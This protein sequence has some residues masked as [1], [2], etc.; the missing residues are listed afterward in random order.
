MKI[1]IIYA[2]ESERGNITIPG[3]ELSFC[4]TGVGKVSAALKTYESCLIEKPD[5]VLG[6]GTAGTVRYDVGDI[7]LCSR[8]L[9]R[10]LFKIADLGVSFE[11][12]FEKELKR[13][14]LSSDS[15]GCVSSGDTFQTKVPASG[16]HSDVYDMEAYG[17]AQACKTLGIPFL[18]LKYVTDIIGRNSMK[19]WE[20]KLEDAKMGLEN[21]LKELIVAV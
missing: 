10:D 7:V 20:E 9:D 1:L 5:L 16:D 3:H 13:F 19:H 8:F 4:M 2:L 21:Y 14:K 11:L 12:D 18:A 17:S 15:S 6:L